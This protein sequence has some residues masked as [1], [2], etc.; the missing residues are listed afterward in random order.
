MH[1][2]VTQKEF[3]EK[4]DSGQKEFENVLMQFFDVS[5]RKF[6]GVT[7]RNSK[8]FF[9]NFH[10]CELRKFRLERCELYY[11][12]FYTGKASDLMIDSCD[13][14]QTLF[15]VF[16]FDKAAF[17]KCNIRWSGILN[18]NIGSVDLS[19]SSRYKF[20]TDLLQVTPQD[21]EDAIKL[22]SGDIE[23]LDLDMRL[24]VKQMIR[25]DMEKY[26]L[27]EP[28]EKKDAYAVSGNRHD[29]S[30]LTYGEAKGMVEAAFGAY[31]PQGGYKTKK[32]AYETD[33]KYKQ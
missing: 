7:I 33:S 29:D 32:T 23:R 15:D 3:L 22:V 25:Q 24:K 27:P 31:G 14:E 18:S 21:I 16:S 1:Q 20:F 8:M 9:C 6:D 5:G 2:V 12:N 17:K 26:D 30:P 4:Y 13:M 10:N 19:T 28:G 11:V